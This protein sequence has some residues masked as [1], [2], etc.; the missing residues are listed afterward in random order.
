MVNIYRSLWNVSLE[1]SF[2]KSRISRVPVVRRRP[3][4]LHATKRRCCGTDL[5]GWR[6]LMGSRALKAEQ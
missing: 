3:S 5:N 4:T 2:E 1:T 6:W